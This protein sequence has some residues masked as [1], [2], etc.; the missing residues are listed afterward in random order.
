MYLSKGQLSYTACAFLLYNNGGGGGGDIL[1]TY[2]V[3]R[4]AIKYRT[5]TRKQMSFI[6]DRVKPPRRTRSSRHRD[7]LVWRGKIWYLV[8]ENK[9]HV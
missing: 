7:I 6:Q 1:L 5:T 9:A 2:R 3:G 4:A 8:Y